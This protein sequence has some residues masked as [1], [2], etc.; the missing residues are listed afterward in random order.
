MEKAKQ[1]VMDELAVKLN[2]RSNSPGCK[3]TKFANIQ[4]S[5]RSPPPVKSESKSKPI[6]IIGGGEIPIASPETNTVTPQK[7]HLASASASATPPYLTVSPPSAATDNT[8]ETNNTNMNPN[9]MTPGFHTPSAKMLSMPSDQSFVSEGGNDDDDST[10]VVRYDQA[11]SQSS[12]PH[13]TAAA[14]AASPS[15]SSPPSLLTP[16]TST[17]LAVSPGALHIATTASA[18][19]P[20]RSISTPSKT[21]PSVSTPRSSSKS[22]HRRRSSSSSTRSAM[23]P[24][25]QHKAFLRSINHDIDD[26][27]KILSSKTQLHWQDRITALKKLS[28][29]CHDINIQA[30]LTEAELAFVFQCL[31]EPMSMQLTELRSLVIKQACETITVL[32]HRLGDEFSIFAPVMTPLCRLTRN[33]KSAMYAP[34]DACLRAIVEEAHSSAILHYIFEALK[35]NGKR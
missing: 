29:M 14:I 26:L 32:V 21:R 27:R 19:S 3:I 33:T 2:G 10:I 25:K 31:V 16:T 30:R 24:S 18:A 5:A 12:P 9:A 15:S 7:H 1:L 28:S 35:S 17:Q 23:T 13:S 20:S 22:H 8:N 34:A 6:V 11:S 4:L